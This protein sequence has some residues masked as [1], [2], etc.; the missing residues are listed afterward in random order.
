MSRSEAHRRVVELTEAL[1]AIP[2][3]TGQERACADAVEALLGPTAMRVERL[4][5]SVVAVGPRRGRPLVVLAGHTDTVP[6]GPALRREGDLLV[7]R[8]ASDMK[9]GLAVMLTLAETLDLDAL[10]YDLGLV[11]Y[12]REEG[13]WVDSG[14]GPVLDQVGWPHQA[15][16]AFCLEPTDNAVQVGCVGTLHARVSFLGRAAH[17]A[18]PW[19]GVNAIHAAGPLLAELAG[20][21]PREVDCGGF[22][23]REVVSVTLAKGG[24]T[25]NVVP[26]RFELNLNYRFAP[27]RPVEDVVE[28]L[29]LLC[30]P[31]EV[32]VVEV[33]PSGRVV[34]DN[35][36]LRRFVAL[37]ATRVEPKQAWT[38]VARFSAVGVDAVNLGP[39]LT[40]QAHQAEEHVD[41][42]YL[43]ESY[44]QFARF[45]AG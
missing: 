36:H 28:E 8:G 40:S 21:P 44:D 27:G 24:T 25:R 1:C 11:F 45:L 41:V 13:P 12:D 37:N 31:A 34:V 35:P 23:F 3:P 9:G 17:S 43:H 18:R 38:D 15:A 29:R 20:R 14:L 26:D 32:E 10:G 22:T 6:G 16:L 42:A 33:A 39:G 5:E 30:G 2:S 4:G 19:Q 7:A